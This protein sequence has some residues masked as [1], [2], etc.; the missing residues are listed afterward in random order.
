MTTNRIN[1][2]GILGFGEIGK[3]IGQICREAGYEIFI[4]ELTYDQ[5]AGKKVDYLHVNITEKENKNLINTIVKTIK[6]IQ[7]KLTIINSTVSTGTT[8]K[9]FQETNLPV[10]H[11][12]VIGVHPH[13]YDSIKYYFP[14]IIGPVDKNSLDLAK[15]HLKKLGLKLE[16][17]DSAEDSETAKLLDL[18]YYAWNILF[19]KWVAEFCQENGL[20][21]EQV[22]TKHNQIY[23]D[24]YSK[25]R[26][27]VARPVL[28]PAKGPIGGH[29]TIPDV[30]LLNNYCQN[31]FTEF[32]LE[33]NK[34]LAKQTEETNIQSDSNITIDSQFGN[35]L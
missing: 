13:L 10:V 19:C 1:S 14:K 9:I 15:K 16:I 6:E 34:H 17:Y 18:T 26:P 12:P 31:R 25:L 7:P 3:A 20:N 11:S 21:F 30:V 35:N 28:T 32:I 27:N 5:L 8:R 2:V 29:C 23:N 22:Y 4:R 33:E 24:G